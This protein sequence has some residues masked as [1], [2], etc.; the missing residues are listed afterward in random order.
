MSASPVEMG[1]GTE[2][3]EVGILVELI[4]MVMHRERRSR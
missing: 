2:T 4:E 1:N 3:V